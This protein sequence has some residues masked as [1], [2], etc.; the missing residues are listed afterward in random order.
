MFRT[1][2]AT[3]TALGLALLALA[4]PAAAQD[5]TQ[6]TQTAPVP[7]IQ[8]MA[9][10]AEDAPVTVVEYASFTC[11]HCAA[12]HENQFKDI[13][14]NYIDT[15]KVRMIFREVYFDRYGLWASMVARC[16]G[17]ERYFGISD[18]IFDQQRDWIS[19]G[20]PTAAV[21][22][23]RRIGKTA[24]L[25]DDDLNACL[26]DSAKAEALVAWYQTNAETDGI[27]ST[28]SFIINGTQYGNMSYADFAKVLDEK[29]G[30]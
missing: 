6:S 30:G 9:L 3:S 26:A 5:A 7:T 20:D 8:E 29:L 17:S 10:G 12:F 28:P 1:L 22:A 16:G 11:N 24:G 18:M 27:D 25:T 13:K 2:T 15:G 14:E 19:G 23:L 4:G 21:E